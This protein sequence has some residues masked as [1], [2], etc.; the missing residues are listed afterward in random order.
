MKDNI[1]KEI[2]KL[3]IGDN[4]SDCFIITR[5]NLHLYKKDKENNPVLTNEW[6]HDRFSLFETYCLPSIKKQI[7]QSFYWIVLFA[8]DTPEEYK[9]RAYTLHREYNAFLP[10]FLN[11]EET[12]DFNGYVKEVIK[13]LKDDSEQLITIRIDNDDA[14][15]YSY[16][17]SAYRLSETQVEAKHLYTYT[18]GIQY[19]V[20]ANFADKIPYPNNHYVIMVDK[21]YDKNSFCH[22]LQFNHFNIHLLDIPHKS[23][24]NND[25]MWAEVIHGRNMDNDFAMQLKHSPLITPPNILEICFGWEVEISKMKTILNIPF[26]LLPTAFHHT[27]NR[28]K[29]KIGIVEKNH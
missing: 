28:L 12:L 3:N 17:D 20:K 25:L 10:F 8:S 11:D 21:K 13:L 5:F 4:K 9:E 29:Q 6:L 18:Y 1:I 27:I 23:I 24:D 7:C 2:A 14:I 22:V 15:H 26:F 16:V 19:Y